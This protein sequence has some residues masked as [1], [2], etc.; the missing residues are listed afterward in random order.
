MIV[1]RLSKKAYARDL[2][3]SG[4]EK[5]G[6]RWNSQ[7]LPALYTAGNRALCTVEVA[8]HLPLYILPTDYYLVSLYIP[9]H[10]PIHQLNPSQLPANWQAQPYFRSTR[11]L[12]DHFLRQASHLVMQVPSAVVQGDYNYLL[13]PRH[14]LMEKITLHA[15]EHFQFDGRLFNRK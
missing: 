12:G 15:V 13:N 11:Q 14:P 7:G 3:G 4:A 10:I 1:Y 6:G 9:D 5:A 2:S 8:V